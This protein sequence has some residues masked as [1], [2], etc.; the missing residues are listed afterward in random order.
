[1]KRAETAE[2]RKVA[3]EI[4]SYDYGEPSAAKSPISMKEFALLKQ[5]ANFTEEDEDWLRTAGEVLANQTKKLVEKWRTVLAA[6]PHL[7]RYS[8]RPDG[9]KDP[10]YS[11]PS[12][13][14]FQQWVLDT[15][16]QPYDQGW[17]NYQQEMA[18]RHTSVK[19]NKTDNV[20]S[21]PGIH[22]RD[23]IA[24]TAVMIDPEIREPFLAAKRDANAAFRIS[25]KIQ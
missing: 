25:A 15:C 8:Q 6:H 3:E 2:F 13:L 24:F 19:K 21:V 16:F 11:E 5:S 9:Q 7:A 20:E 14:R 1:M 23:V 18:L 10:R 17:L 4:P 12:G 22:L